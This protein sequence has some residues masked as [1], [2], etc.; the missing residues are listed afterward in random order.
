MWRESRRVRKPMSEPELP[1]AAEGQGVR[2]TLRR[3]RGREAGA[4]VAVTV[5]S[6]PGR[7]DQ[8]CVCLCG[9]TGF[10]PRPKCLAAASPRA[11][12]S[13]APAGRRGGRQ[14]G[15]GEAGSTSPP[16]P[17]PGPPAPLPQP[18][19]RAGEHPR[20]GALDV[21]PFVPVRGV[22]MDD[23][24]LCAQ[25]FGRRLAEELGVPGESRK[26]TPPWQ[27]LP[28]RPAVPA[29]SLQRTGRRA[30]CPAPPSCP[31]KPSRRFLVG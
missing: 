28:S 24:V 4:A 21:C 20:M 9:E 22:S 11:P 12:G 23:C 16:S 3:P 6:R 25:A 2:R 15:G 18:P 17:R 10:L 1:G 14:V 27:G 13:A 31:A 26:G 30:V 5:A 7:A 19:L 29:G 8:G